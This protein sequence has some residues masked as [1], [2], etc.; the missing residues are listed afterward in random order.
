VLNTLIFTTGVTIY[1]QRFPTTSQNPVAT[2]SARATI[3]S[4]NILKRT[5]ALTFVALWLPVSMHCLLETIPGF[6]LLDWCCDTG[7][8]QSANGGC[9]Q[10]TCGEIEAGLYRVED[11]PTLT[12]SLAIILAMASPVQALQ[13]PRPTATTLL[14][15]G[16]SPPDLPQTWQFSHRAALPVRAP[17]FVS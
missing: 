13:P 2:R 6:N 14:P 1:T 5:I 10:D 3:A 8:S 9:A 15:T 12:P 16:S 17:S 4:V 7:A 11:N